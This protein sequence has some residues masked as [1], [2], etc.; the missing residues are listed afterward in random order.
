MAI[1][2]IRNISKDF[3][4][5][6]ALDNVSLSIQEGEAFGL[7]GGSGSGKTTLGR[8][9]LKLLQPTSGEI[10]Y[11]GGFS[12][13]DYQ[14]VFQNPFSSLNPR[15]RIGDILREPLQLHGI[16]RNIGEILR[17]VELSESFMERYPHELSG[18]EKQRICIARAVSVQP[19][20]VV[21]D[22]PVSSL[23]MTISLDILKLLKKI[24]ND[25]NLTYMLISHDLSVIRYMCGRLAVMKNG[26]VVEMGEAAGM[27]REPKDPYTKLLIDSIPKLSAPA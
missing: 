5:I 9:I 17:E 23:D 3:G 24:K 13:K 18:G 7:V 11:S 25:L 6:R 26:S 4:G 8:V 15:M 27:F 21:L 19:R 1:V 12:R 20:F 22:E 10:T 16:K 2:D 14:I